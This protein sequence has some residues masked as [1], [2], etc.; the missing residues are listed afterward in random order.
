MATIFKHNNVYIQCKNLQ[1]KLKKLRLNIEDIEI[2]KDNIPD[3]KIE[4][5]FVAIT[6]IVKEED[7]SDYVITYYIFENSKGNYLFGINKPNLDYI[8]HFG[9]DTSDYKIIDTCKGIPDKK[10]FKWNPD[11]KTGIK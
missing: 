3:D 11:T 5:E 1:K 7:N 4:Q 10:Y 8:K 9:Y 2:I 6:R